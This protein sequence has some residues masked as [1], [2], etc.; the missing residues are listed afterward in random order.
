[1]QEN[2][3]AAG[4]IFL[5]ER[6]MIM[7][8]Y[9]PLTRY[10]E[11]IELS[12][13]VK[14]LTLIELERILGFKVPSSACEHRAWWSNPTSPEDHPHAQSWL[15]AG[16]KV[17]AVDQSERRV[18]FQRIHSSSFGKSSLPANNPIISPK[19]Q[20]IQIPA[21][22]LAILASPAGDH[23]SEDDVKRSLE[24]WLIANGWQVQVAWGHESGVDIQAHKGSRL[25]LIEVKGSGS[26]SAMRVN[27][28]LGALGELLQRMDKPDAS[29]SIA[30]PDLQQF[31]R[32][33]DRFPALACQRMQITALFVDKNGN[34]AQA[35]DTPLSEEKF[36]IAGPLEG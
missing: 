33:W 15:A 20:A 30:F 17:D 12:T 25:W 19:P 5:S 1:L 14:S 6:I 22:H 18:H 11:N 31:R 35:L 2:P 23:L 34:V 16:W 8:K 7:S 26:L 10:L 21:L 27:Y 24:K 13:S 32:L 28:F 29:Y 9:D 4:Y 36:L 3:L